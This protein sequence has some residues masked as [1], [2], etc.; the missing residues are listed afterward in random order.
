MVQGFER[1]DV[2]EDANSKSRALEASSVP[3]TPVMRPQPSSFAKVGQHE[4]QL[5]DILGKADVG[6]SKYIEKKSESWILEGQMA[7]ARG[8]TEEE[9]S[10]TGNHFTTVGWQ[11]MNGKIAQ[12]EVFQ[13][14]AEFIKGDGKK[15]SPDQYQQRLMKMYDETTKS[16]PASSQDAKD[17]MNSGALE[18]FPRLVAEQTKLHNLYN[19]DETINSGKRAIVSTAETDGPEKARELAD[20]ASFPNLNDEDYNG[21]VAGAIVDGYTLTKSDKV[22][23]AIAGG[24]KPSP[25]AQPQVAGILNLI[26]K[27]ESKNDYNNAVGGR[28]PNLTTMTL[29]DV[30]ATQGRMLAEKRESTAVGKYQIIRDTMT[31]LKKE[32]GLTGT[33]VFNEELQDRMAVHLMKQKGLDKFLAGQM[34]PEQFQ[35]QLATVWAG[36]PKDKT[37][38]SHYA[39]VG[40]NRATVQ[41]G[42][43]MAALVNTQSGTGMYS[44]LAS[45]GMD[46]KDIRAVMSAK[47]SYERDQSTKFEASRLTVEKDIVT[48]APTLDDDQLFMRIDEAR[49][50]GGY[51]DQWANSQWNASMAERERVRKEGAKSLKVDTMIDTMTVANGSKEEQETAIDKIGQRALE[52]NPDALN[53]N[54]PNYH[55]AKGQMQQE[56]FQ[57]MHANRITDSRI[58]NGWGTAVLGDIVDKEGRTKP[59]AI[60]AYNSYQQAW[61]ATNDKAWALGLADDAT[62]KL[63]IMADSYTGGSKENAEQA[64]AKAAAFIHQQNQSKFEAP[65]PFWSDSSKSVSIRQDLQDNTIPGLFKM[66]GASRQEA[67]MSWT[68][69]DD[70]VQKASMSPHVANLIKAEAARL[71]PS[72]KN[73]QDQ[74]AAVSTVMAQAAANVRNKAEFVVGTYIHNGED[75]TFA[76]KIGMGGVH[77]GTN[78]VVSRMMQE[79]GPVVYGDKW[80]STSI[81]SLPQTWYVK[82][83]GISKAAQWVGHVV[84]HP[85]E[86]AQAPFNGKTSAMSAVAQQR[87]VGVPDFEVLL[88]PKGNALHL[89]PYLDAGR[90]RQGPTFTISA[91]QAKEAAYYLNKGDEAGF[92][93]WAEEKK[94][95]LPKY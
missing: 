39:G 79:F 46:S 43:V 59:A 26:G 62:Q 88:S 66:F 9:L 93:K 48:A 3:L 24:A 8:V 77:N 7:R 56:V 70:S 1:R 20:R 38:A 65:I 72:V 13:N 19:K 31:G 78:M 12:D 64:L 47:D 86:I 80:Q 94:K 87:L 82:E 83:P 22:A 40:S 92:K 71:W 23:Q 76:E 28:I 55:Q 57:F 33:E 60:E 14:E 10:K 17:M 52:N 4:R 75:K 44:Q 25:D 49:V 45:M 90:T 21:M 42:E 34:A 32:M 51:S 18:M 85:G 95:T 16:L 69:N 54:S 67:Q 29:N 2:I 68:I 63:F 50:A 74:G 5:A 91:E 58:K 41:P 27:A 37:G 6:L 35:A 15:M 73:W 61:A 11:A 30:E 84:T 81:H 89:S 53:P 36:I